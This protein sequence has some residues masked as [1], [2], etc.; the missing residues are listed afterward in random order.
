MATVEKVAWQISKLTRV[1]KS[2]KLIATVDKVA[3]QVET[4]SELVRI[5]SIL[6]TKQIERTDQT[7]KAGFPSANR[8]MLGSSYVTVSFAEQNKVQV[9]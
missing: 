3:L 8:K 2:D 4:G 9:N 6:R 7:D 1:D 5:R